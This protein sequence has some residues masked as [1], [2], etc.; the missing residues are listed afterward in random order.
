VKPAGPHRLLEPVSMSNTRLRALLTLAS[1]G[2]LASGCT[3]IREHRGY[4]VDQV[5]VAAVQPGVDNRESVQA[6]LG[7]PTFT[8]QFDQRD[9]YYVSRETKQLAFNSPRPTEQT[10]LHIR[11][12]QAGTVEAVDRTGLELARNISPDGHETPTLGSD[13]SFFEDIFGNIGAVGQ[14]GQGGQTADN[15]Q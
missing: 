9:W 13:R 12:N 15:P 8:G 11:F 3:A 4:V 2:L 6:T 10:V 14:R 7:R 1:V 5:L